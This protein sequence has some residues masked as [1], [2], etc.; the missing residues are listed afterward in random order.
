MK[1]QPGRVTGGVSNESRAEFAYRG[2]QAFAA[3]TKCEDDL[4]TLAGDMLCD[5]LHLAAAAGRDTDA[6]LER[7]VRLAAMHYEAETEGGDF[8]EGDEEPPV[9]T[10]PE[11]DWETMFHGGIRMQRMPH[12]LNVGDPDTNQPN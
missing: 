6:F 4:E 12:P 9:I 1:F 8:H 5:M 7:I 3:V 10:T 2:L 11:Y